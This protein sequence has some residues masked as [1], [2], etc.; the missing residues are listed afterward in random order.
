MAGK[1][2]HPRE[3]GPRARV[4]PAP[5]PRN[6]PSAG[7][8]AWAVPAARVVVA[9]GT[10]ALLLVAFA[11]HPLGDHFTESD[12]YE[13]AAGGRSLAR[14]NIDFARY[15]VIGPVYEFLLAIPA[16]LGI[17]AFTFARLLSVAAVTILSLAWLE[18]VRR[19]LGGLAALVTVT[20]L[21]ANAVLFR[22][23]YSST[24][25]VTALAF[26]AV[27]LFALLAWRGRA[28]PWVAGA[29]AA[30]AT[31]T[32]YNS[33]YLLPGAIAFLLALADGPPAARRAALVRWLA[34]FA[35]VLA[36]WTLASA[37]HGHWPGE[38]LFS[39]AT[40]YASPSARE[41][42][43]QDR[44]EGRPAGEEDTRGPIARVVANAPAHLREDARQVLGWPTAGL[45][46][47][48]LVI[49][50]AERRAGAWLPLGL[51]GALAFLALV[52]VFYSDRY[53]LA[54]L[55]FYLSLAGAAAA[56]PRL[57]SL[58][59]RAR[60]LVP[61]LLVAWPLATSLDASVQV[62]R[63]VNGQLPRDVLAAAPAL[64]REL[65]PD[66]GIIARKGALA[67]YGGGRP[68]AFPRLS[69][70]AELAAHAEANR[71][72]YLYYSWYEGML[73][74]EFLYLLDTTTAIPGLA[75]IASVREPPALLYRIEEGFGR[76]PAW[77]A[78]STQRSVHLARGE[79]RALE[80]RDPWTAWD[81]HS[82][83]GREAGLAG[84]W[85]EALVHFEAMTR[86]RPEDAR[87]WVYAGD[88]RATLGNL[89]PA[90]AAYDRALAIDPRSVGALLGMGW[91]FYAEQRWSEA[92]AA[93]RPI[94]GAATDGRTLD[95]M[96]DAFTRIGDSASV[97]RAREALASRPPP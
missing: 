53:S 35:I 10:L 9:L 6:P 92:A 95:A 89:G 64:R 50:I 13:Y 21:L 25:D 43:V 88:A 70:L 44:P 4:S 15:G 74:P 57:A 59:G 8:P 39:N 67:F 96:I 27:S 33:A 31:L 5:A 1:A 38:D 36:P 30:L 40:F 90:R 26:Q 28:A 34:A 61:V 94:I 12:F 42:N 51:H 19:S 52:P 81:A 62:Q 7:V 3:S 82:F 83:L 78:D 86:S 85:E 47:L 24:T 14:G 22:Y 93:W 60:W 18:I 29:A 68:V 56:S 72:R 75:R 45:C 49:L 16:L 65:R 55:P 79:I 91:T 46:V 37:A 73:R 11:T 20:L 32:R 71:A 41:R 84:R 17:P 23:G 87:G 48:G 97:E 2:Q 66:D 54:V 76:D 77:M 63:Y 58:A 69:S 80:G